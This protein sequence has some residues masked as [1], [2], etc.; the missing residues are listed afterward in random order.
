MKDYRPGEEQIGCAARNR[1]K[2]T[3]IASRPV[4]A[5]SFEPHSVAW[6]IDRTRLVVASIFLGATVACGEAPEKALRHEQTEK[7]WNEDA[8]RLGAMKREI[9][10]LVREPGCS[11]TSECVAVAFGAKP[12]GGPW[13]YLVY[14]RM[15]V[16]ESAL[17]DKVKGYNHFNKVI[18]ERHGLVSDC[19]LVTEP[20][21]DCVN[22]LCVIPDKSP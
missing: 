14:S 6:V 8:A 17:L 16:D 9:E 13:T 10:E 22:G 4:S 5:S 21:L 7:T 3:E 12:C 18:N 15:S 2:N 19:M 11:L 1:R 20:S